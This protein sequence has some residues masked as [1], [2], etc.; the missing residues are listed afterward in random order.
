ML[1]LLLG[2]GEV[3]MNEDV[4]QGDFLNRQ[5]DAAFLYAYLL[6][7]NEQAVLRGDKG[8]T[9]NVNAPWGAG[10]TFFLSRFAEQLRREGKRVAEVNAWRDDHA[11]DPIFAVMAAILKAVGRTG[12]KLKLR[13]A[14]KNNAG[15]IAIRSGQGL[16][17]RAA[18]V[19]VGEATADGIGD[20]LM[21]ALVQAGEITLGEYADKAL[22]RFEEGQQAIDEFRAGLIAEVEGKDP[23]FVLVDELDRCRPTYAISVLERIK[24][25]FDVPNI[26]FIFATNAEQLTCTIRSVYGTEFDAE[27]YLHRFFD[28]TYQFEVPSVRQFIEARRTSLNLKMERFFVL[29]GSDP[30]DCIEIVSAA[31][32]LSLR[33]IEQCLDILWSVVNFTDEKAPIPLLY[34]FPLIAAYHLR[35]MDAFNIGCGEMKWD[36]SGVG[37]YPGFFDDT[38]LFERSR[39]DR[40]RERHVIVQTTLRDVANAFRLLIERGVN[41]P[42]TTNGVAYDLVERFRTAEFNALRVKQVTEKVPSVV[43]AYGSMIRRAGKVNVITPS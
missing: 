1:A 26:I 28:R 20:D 40:H 6:Q 16:L 2:D 12:K 25:L 33:D 34:L 19:V 21:K 7:R 43:S 13:E 3:F 36:G 22:E 9:I 10:K 5:E 11:E 8:T 15:K 38:V 17:K 14:L 35:E 31:K 30:L 39:Y 4:W 29:P 32:A 27:R 23:L 18:A 42:I 24:H 37:P 41:E